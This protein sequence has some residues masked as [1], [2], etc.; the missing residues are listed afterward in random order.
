MRAYPGH[1][2]AW[3]ALLAVA[4]IALAGDGMAVAARRA[5]PG[6]DELL[7]EG[8]RALAEGEHKIAV[9]RCA[10]V[11]KRYPDCAEAA[12]AQ[13]VM[14]AAYEG[15]GKRLKAAYAYEELLKSHPAS[16]DTVE[17]ISHLAD[18]GIAFQEAEQPG[19]LKRAF[20]RN[21]LE[22]AMNVYRM[23]INNVP[24]DSR[25]AELEYRVGE[26]AFKLGDCGMAALEWDTVVRR[27][28]LS[29]WVEKSFFGAAEAAFRQMLPAGYDGSAVEEAEERLKRFMVRFPE[30]S[31]KPK[32]YELLA[33]IADR[34]AEHLFLVGRFYEKSGSPSAARIVYRETQDTYP[35]TTW[36]TRSGERLKVV[37]SIAPAKKERGR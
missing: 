1:I 19:R 17:A 27:Y 24:Y 37:A 16:D 18:I 14:G 32:V 6:A 33:S 4:A 22:H 30:S 9:K 26:C 35:G 21:S 20:T 8:E 5:A 15:L 13:F 36:A 25:S 3:A 7:R 29:R 23:V 31:L 12:R 10:Q 28:P 2:R 34:Q 11:L